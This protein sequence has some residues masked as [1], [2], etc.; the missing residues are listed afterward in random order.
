MLCSQRVDE[1][2]KIDEQKAWMDAE[3][4]DEEEEDAEW[5][6]LPPA[7]RSASAAAAGAGTAP[8][9]P[10]ESKK[11]PKFKRCLAAVEKDRWNADAW[12]ALMN[13]VQLL[14][15]LEA[16][17]HYEKFLEL[18]PTSVRVYIPCVL[19]CMAQR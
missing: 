2:C 5:S 10:N 4:E 19:I 1:S 14:S 18:Y 9:D 3:E 13:E 12:I 6:Q 11:T 7:D 16:R 15:V 17:A 8:Q